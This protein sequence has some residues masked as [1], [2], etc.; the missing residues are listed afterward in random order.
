[1]KRRE[2]SLKGREGLMKG[3]EYSLKRRED[4][5]KGRE[6]SLKGREELVNLPYLFACLF[7]KI[8]KKLINSG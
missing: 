6:D 8:N 3:R 1:L 4:L 7:N 2:D 5:M